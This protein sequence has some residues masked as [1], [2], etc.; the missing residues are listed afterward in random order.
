MTNVVQLD[1]QSFYLDASSGGAKSTLKLRMGGAVLVMFTLPKC[2][3][4]STF[5]PKFFEIAAAQPSIN[6]ALCDLAAVKN[7]VGKSR[8]STT[9]LQ[10]VPT[11]ILYAEGAPRAKFKGSMNVPSVASF[12]AKGI[13]AITANQTAY[14]NPMAQQQPSHSMVTPSSQHQMGPIQPTRQP[15]PPTATSQ[16]FST[17]SQ[18]PYASLGNPEEDDDSCLLMP[19]GICPYNQPWSS[20]FKTL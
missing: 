11:I 17:A 1:D 6:F 15:Q 4:C 16:K 8:A 9:P 20:E 2:R 19:G 5:K 3:G 18:E 14:R 7:L 13:R 12:I 10:S